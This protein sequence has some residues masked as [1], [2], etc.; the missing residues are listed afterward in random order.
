MGTDVVEYTSYVPE[1]VMDAPLYT[2]AVLF[3]IVAFTSW[4]ICIPPTVWHFQQ[5]NVA[6]GSFIL[7]II[8]QNFFNSI[9]P[10]IWPRDNLIDWWDGSV[11]CDIQVRLQI[12]CGVALAV[13]SALIVRKLARVMDTS[14]I[15]VS[16]S[17][18]SKTKEIIWEAV[19]CWGAPL[20]L[21]VVYYVIQPVRY[22]LYGIVGCIATFD[23]SWPSIVIIYIWAPIAMCF[24]AYWAGTLVL[25]LAE[26]NG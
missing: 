19:W 21:M 10:L 2:S 20:L 24:A 11:W 3:P 13:S 25:A 8:L 17:R 16:N 6:M 5:S 1:V 26:C 18:S 15:T 22:M 7:W 4:I 12:G 9:N 23:T 14:N